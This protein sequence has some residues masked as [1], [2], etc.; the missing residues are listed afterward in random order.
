V[1]GGVYYAPKT[2]EVEITVKPYP[3]YSHEID[4]SNGGEKWIAKEGYEEAPPF[5][6]DITNT[7]NQPM[8]R[9]QLRLSG[10][11]ADLFTITKPDGSALDEQD[12]WSKSLF[13]EGY[14]VLMD[15]LDGTTSPLLPYFNVAPFDV[16]PKTGLAAGAYNVEVEVAWVSY[17]AILNNYGAVGMG[18][19]THQDSVALTFVVEPLIGPIDKIDF[20]DDGY[21][22]GA[23]IE[24]YEGSTLK[25][26]PLPPLYMELDDSEEDSP[27]DHIEWD[28]PLDTSVG[29]AGTTGQFTY[30]VYFKESSVYNPKQYTV[31]VKVLAKPVRDYFFE[32]E[33]SYTFKPQNVGYGNLVGSVFSVYN[34]GTAEMDYVSVRLTGEDASAFKATYLNGRAMYTNVNFRIKE[35]G[36]GYGQ[37]T[38]YLQGRQYCSYMITPK[39]NLAAGDYEATAEVSWIYLRTPLQNYGIDGF[40]YDVVTEE[41]KISFSVGKT[42]FPYDFPYWGSDVRAYEGSKLSEVELPPP[43]IPGDIDR[44]E[45]DQDGDT[46]IGKAGTEE[47]FSYTIYPEDSA[48]YSPKTYKALV[49]SV[50]YPEWDLRIDQTEA[51]DFGEVEG[52]VPSK[53]VTLTNEGNMYYFYLNGSISGADPDAFEV[54]A[55]DGSALPDAT[56]GT[57]LENGKQLTSGSLDGPGGT[58]SFGV[59]PKAGLEPGTYK[60]TIEVDAWTGTFELGNYGEMAHA[61]Y[62]EEK[63]TFDVSVTVKEP[64]EVVKPA[65]APNPFQNLVNTLKNLLKNLA[66]LLRR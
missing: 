37:L 47:T 46:V 6:V 43:Y 18:Y 7:G 28:D 59:S 49:I 2:Y 31:D 61:Y 64:S 14:G 66:A 58:L 13:G 30:T 23:A 11:D 21:W 32:P 20:P 27:A 8:T 51:L 36:D 45:W 19:D 29:A 25:D 16:T 34:N 10:K 62:K 26:A 60:A 5:E 63:K 48:R 35:L 33:K 24:V 1:V 15:S 4:A 56:S 40:G 9:L 38:D 53:V 42:E 44:I 22:W 12:S 55:A 54:T 3:D 52:V 17:T 65:P 39:A 50:E 41:C 57:H